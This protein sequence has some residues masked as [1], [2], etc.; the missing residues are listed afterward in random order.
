MRSFRCRFALL[1]GTLILLALRPAAANDEVTLRVA[2]NTLPISLDIHEQLSIGVLQ[3]AHLTFD[4][5]VRWNRHLTFEPRLATSWERPDAT[6]M[7]F[8]LRHGVVFHS[9]NPF[10]AQDVA[11]TV[12]RLKRSPD[13]KA[14]FDP[15]TRVDVIDDYTVDLH[16]RHPYPLLLNLATYIFPM[17]SRFYSGETEDGRDK[18]A[19]VKNGN[20][21]ASRHLSGTGPFTVEQIHPGTRIDLERFPDY[22]DH[23]SPGNVD[24]LTLTPIGENA[25]RVAALLS[26]DVDF[27]S[28]VPAN[29]LERV[30]R[31]E[32]VKLLT[33]PG[34]RITM[35][36]LNQQRVPAFRDPRVRRAMAYAVDQ[37]AIA[38]RLLKGFVTPAAQMSPEGYAGHNPD[39]VPRHDLEKAR[40]LMADAGYSQGFEVTLMAPNNRYVNDAQM[41]QVALAVSAMLAKINI[42]VD[43]QTL[44]NSQYWE[45]FDARAADIMMIGW[46]SDT[47]DSANFFEYLTFCPDSRTGVGFYNASEYCNPEVDSLVELANGET[48]PERRAGMLKRAEAMV[49]DDAPF[50][51]LYW[52]NLAWAA[53]DRVDI[54]PVLNVM[55]MPYLG[56]VV[57]EP[58]D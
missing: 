37:D 19:I 17:D 10:T 28:P 14:I 40:Q 43:F 30:R 13:F 33:M 12:K 23:D 49:Y 18:A 15:I 39:L 6:T 22:W 55:N 47:N 34:T 3:L 50:I 1:L 27:I 24:H 58:R 48:D 9:G 38:T 45:Q 5:L 2:Y 32:G 7:R 8:H 52:Q 4:P 54:E 53:A 46:Y 16:T 57:V 41:A 31:A 26:G 21:F 29:A 56:D 11:W 35:L 25:T 36:Q 42:K 51:P 20:S 44:P